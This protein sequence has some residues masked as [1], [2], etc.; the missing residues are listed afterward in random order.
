LARAAPIG[1]STAFSDAQARRRFRAARNQQ[2]TDLY[3]AMRAVKASVIEVSVLEV[4]TAE[5]ADEQE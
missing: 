4:V 1:A 3:S 2:P 5:T